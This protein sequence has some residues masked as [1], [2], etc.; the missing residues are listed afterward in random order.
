[1][2][3]SSSIREGSTERSCTDIVRGK[4]RRKSSA[5]AGAG[6]GHS[7]IVCMGCACVHTP[8]SACA[9]RA[10]FHISDRHTDYPANRLPAELL[11]IREFLNSYLAEW[12]CTVVKTPPDTVRQPWAKRGTGGVSKGT[13]RRSMADSPSAATAPL[14][15]PVLRFVSQILTFSRTPAQ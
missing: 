10:R 11:V 4:E 9:A 14:A 13:A 12:R 6:Q 2:S 5:G 3:S 8:P 7:G 1:M 15:N